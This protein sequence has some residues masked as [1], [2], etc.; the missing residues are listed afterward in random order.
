MTTFD[1][2][3]GY[4]NSIS[5]GIDNY[6]LP[7][8][9][10]GQYQLISNGRMIYNNRLF[11]NLKQDNTLEIFDSELNENRIMLL[12]HCMKLHCL[13]YMLDDFLSTMSVFQKDIGVK[14]YKSQVDSKQ[15][16]VDDEN[17][18]IDNIVFSMSESYGED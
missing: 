6:Y 9:I 2:I 16:R 10:E 12:G 8:T 15:R 3:Y 4:F 7:T 5:N 18:I 14:D 13:I 11:T 1:E 17:K